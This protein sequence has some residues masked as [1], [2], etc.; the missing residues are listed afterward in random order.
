M[1]ML[2]W[3]FLCASYAC[4]SGWLVSIYAHPPPGLGLSSRYQLDPDHPARWCASYSSPALG[5]S[6]EAH[7]LAHIKSIFFF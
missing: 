5:V 2:K 4:G 1:V 6:R 7:I 3:E